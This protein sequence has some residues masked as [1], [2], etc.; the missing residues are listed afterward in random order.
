MT[1][2]VIDPAAAGADDP[3]SP[4]RSDRGSAE[5]L[6]AVRARLLQ[7]RLAGR[8]TAR[9]GAAAPAARRTGPIPLSAGHRWRVSNPGH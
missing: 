9:T 1:T 4:A 5:D 3:A 7:Q 8:P 6:A 2:G